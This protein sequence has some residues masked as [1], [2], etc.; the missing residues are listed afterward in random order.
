M[1]KLLLLA[2]T[3]YI[4][5]ICPQNS[6][7]QQTPLCRGLSEYKRI[8][9]DP[10]IIPPLQAAV[11]HPSI[12]P[13]IERA[14]PYVYRAIEIT[15]PAISRAHSQ[16][17]QQV[18]P[19]W[20]KYVVP[21]WNKHIAPRVDTTRRALAPYHRR[22]ERAYAQS[23][24]PSA[25]R[26]LYNL[27]RWQRQARPYILLTVS[28]THEGYNAA[29]PYTAPLVKRSGHALQRLAL[30]LQ[31]QRQHFVDPHVAK[32]WD[33]VKELSRGKQ[34]VPIDQ[35]VFPE[36]VP[37]FPEEL[38]PPTEGVSPEPVPISV[39]LPEDAL[40]S[41]VTPS[42][43]PIAQHTS[44]GSEPPTPSGTSTAA[45]SASPGTPEPTDS[46]IQLAFQMEHIESPEVETISGDTVPSDTP[47]APEP[48]ASV[49]EP[50]LE[51]PGPSL[52][53]GHV[54][55]ATPTPAV[56][57]TTR[58]TLTG[59]NDEIDMDAFY[60]ELGLD[61][62]L[63][64]SRNSQQQTFESPPPESEEDRAEQQRLRAEETAR[65][66]AD[67]ELRHAKWEGELEAQIERSRA[68]LHSRLRILRDAAAAELSSSAEVRRAIDE[69]ASEAEKYIKGAEIYLKNLKGEVRKREE[70]LALWDRVVDKV[71]GKFAER[72]AAAESTVSQLYHFLR[73]AEL[74]EVRVVVFPPP[75]IT[76]ADLVCLG[77]QRHSE[78]S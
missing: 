57:N 26:V 51:E 12:A 7:Y 21:Q 70:K 15:S 41:A 55:D 23:F 54:V 2:F 25:Q 64:D 13:H 1:T 50:I 43:S 65:K 61:E 37:S 45:G 17:N 4:F 59:N 77:R 8:V 73:D 22:V 14:R 46:T 34:T 71:A 74:Q 67:I 69:L 53:R 40:T 6:P 78:S 24:A 5:S 31:E 42:P 3:I 60:A 28:K 39:E 76:A 47:R 72:L 68:E 35:E 11:S 38:K 49:T 33:K 52:S 56:E 20:E 27:Q 29:K 32:I 10:Y 18:I 63:G 36:V 62:P 30:F 16:W 58:A 44:G 66:R 75:P 19:Q 9:L 48:Q